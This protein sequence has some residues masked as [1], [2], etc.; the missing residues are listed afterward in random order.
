M[1]IQVSHQ[2]YRTSLS[3]GIRINWL[4]LFY[5][6]RCTVEAGKNHL[7]RCQVVRD[8]IINCFVHFSDAKV[9]LTLAKHHLRVASVV[10][11]QTCR[12]S[13]SYGT[14][15]RSAN[16]YQQWCQVAWDSSIDFVCIYCDVEVTP[17]PAI[18]HLLMASEASHQTC[19]TSIYLGTSINWL[20]LFFCHSWHFGDCKIIIYWDRGLETA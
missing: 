3:L 7:L 20:E 12:T 5:R 18:N 14:S 17:T 13:L 19:S 8:I 4:A 1:S 15:I 9:T 2:I 11:H 10:S 6:H 16:S